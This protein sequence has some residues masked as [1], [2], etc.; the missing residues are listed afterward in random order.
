MKR[1]RLSMLLFCI[2][3][4]SCSKKVVDT[5]EPL[6]GGASSTVSDDAD[7]SEEKSRLKE[8]RSEITEEIEESRTEP[9]IPS[10]APMESEESGTAFSSE[11]EVVGYLDSPVPSEDGEVSHRDIE[12]RIEE[13]SRK[14]R[15]LKKSKSRDSELVFEEMRPV[16]SKPRERIS[17]AAEVKA[18]AHNDNE[19]F[20]SYQ[21]FCRKTDLPLLK[22]NWNVDERVI[23][24]V[25]DKDDNPV[26]NA[27]VTV[28]NGD[29]SWEAATPA[30]GE[31]VL[32]PGMDLGD[33]YHSANFTVSSGS[34]TSK[35]EKSPDPAVTLKL[36]S[37]RILPQQ[38]PLQ[39]CFLVDATGSMGDEIQQLKDVMFSIHSRIVSH[40]SKPDASFSLVA[41]RDR[42]D[43]F[44]VKGHPFTSSIDTFQLRLEPLQ[45]RGGGDTPEDICAG[46]QYAM[47]SLAWH[48]EAV[49]FVFMMGDAPPH[50][51][52]YPEKNYLW[53]SRTAREKGVRIVSVGASGLP[54][55]GEF[56]FRQA[57][58][59]TGGEFVFLH[60]G[61]TGES[62]GA[63]TKSDPGKVS[64]HTGSNYNSRRLDDIVVDIVS[65]D[66][67][68]LLPP[69][70]VVRVKS[71]PG[72]NVELYD[73]RL[74]DLLR[75][76]FRKELPLKGKTLVLS[77]FAVE[78]TTL[79][80]LSDFLWE[81]ALEK[82]VSIAPVNVI[83][84]KKLEQI[85]QENSLELTGLTPES[86][87]PKIGK[88]LSADYL[89]F[90]R[91]HYIG[92][93]RMCHMRLVDCASGRIMSASRIRL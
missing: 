28:E 74:T 31:L 78:D 83:E 29:F 52:R 71:D 12:A 89:V 87:D 65:R 41:Y 50:V 18:A 23:I 68:Y 38:V 75:Q 34:V 36:G 26:H 57:A 35:L 86:A 49:K 76:V 25:V 81:S 79:G 24:R 6:Y 16:P 21:E 48:P 80:P 8:K 46:L 77:P 93:V 67:G 70:K 9:E 92:S 56:V 69:S 90:S 5:S 27:P 88:L 62:S 54:L 85:L 17:R 10:S 3:L 47:D 53:A 11:E 13:L 44:L 84:R 73:L 59:L 63:G 45:A 15:E 33:D 42:G 22:K 72:D 55:K 40:P 20:F 7:K 14:K 82:T 58:L 37:K 2:L 30:S 39:I 32:F 51:D 64:H 66:L 19:E 91:L 1:L 61:E 60:Y 4:V 43:A